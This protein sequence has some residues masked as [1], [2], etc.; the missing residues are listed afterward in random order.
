LPLGRVPLHFA[1]N[2]TQLVRDQG[3]DFTFYDPRIGRVTNKTN[4]LSER[5]V[6]IGHVTGQYRGRPV[7]IHWVI[8][9]PVDDMLNSIKANEAIIPFNDP[10]RP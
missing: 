4:K 2:P 5:L 3:D 10:P 9:M 7:Y 8:D 6:K 1:P